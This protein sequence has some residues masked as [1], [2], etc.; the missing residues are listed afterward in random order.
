MSGRKT[1]IKISRSDMKSIIES[2]IA[3]PTQHTQ[4]YAETLHDNYKMVEYSNQERFGGFLNVIFHKFKKTYLYEFSFYGFYN[5]VLTV[6][7]TQR[8][9]VSGRHEVYY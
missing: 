1:F 5:F 7:C 8:I 9:K 6:E 3:E 4:E 2:Y